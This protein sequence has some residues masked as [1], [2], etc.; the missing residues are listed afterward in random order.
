MLDYTLSPKSKRIVVEL[1]KKEIQRLA[2]DANLYDLHRLE[3]PS[4]KSKS[5]RRKALKAVLDELLA[6]E[7]T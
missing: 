2:V 3:L 7:P 1:L 6:Q 4:T 5:D